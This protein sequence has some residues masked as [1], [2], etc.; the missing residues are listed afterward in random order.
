MLKSFDK[1][2]DVNEI[3][4]AL[5]TDGGVI[6]KNLVDKELLDT[7]KA[8]FR[9]QF[10]EAGDYIENDFNGYKTKRLETVLGISRSAADLLAHPLIMK[11]ADKVLKPYCSNY[12]I[13]SSSGIEIWPGE[14]AQVLHRDDEI[15]PHRMP[16]V[17]FQVAALWAMDEFTIENGATHVIPGSHKW[18]DEEAA[19]AK[20][21][22]TVQAVMSRG[23]VLLYFGTTVH[24]GGENRSDKP[25]CALVTTYSLGWLRQEENHY[26][27]IP[28]E[29]AESYPE[30]I[31]QLMGFASY[32]RILGTYPG[33]PIAKEIS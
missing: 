10:D 14:M 22:D 23:S 3:V 21:E 29:V 32:S 4:E 19:G 28:K 30:H 12:R 18:T 15:Y 16:G 27:A 33:S 9:P 31:Q 8:D 11:V 1:N 6:V 17:E 26:M 5:K 2:A 7:V 13:G 25:R 24:G 20:R